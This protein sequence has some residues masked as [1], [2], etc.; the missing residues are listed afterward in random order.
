MNNRIDTFVSSLRLLGPEDLPRLEDGE[1]E[2]NCEICKTPYSTD[3]PA[4]QTPCG[5]NFGRDCLRRWLL[6]D[7]ARTCP[8]CRARLV[9]FSHGPR[10][11][12]VGDSIVLNHPVTEDDMLQVQFDMNAQGHAI[13]WTEL[14]SQTL[15]HYRQCFFALLL[16][17]HNFDLF[18][19]EAQLDVASVAR[20]NALETSIDSIYSYCTP[21]ELEIVGT[22]SRRQH[23]I[24]FEDLDQY[25]RREVAHIVWAYGEGE[26]RFLDDAPFAWF[27]ENS[28]VY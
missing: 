18:V 16:R 2:T 5:H 21:E 14:L 8:M 1:Y 25:Q 22:E 13:N 23:V 27:D 28:I 12:F 10:F 20:L 11:R 6:S 24:E 3:D 9:S 17:S 7:P 15:W 26:F 4:V 19:P